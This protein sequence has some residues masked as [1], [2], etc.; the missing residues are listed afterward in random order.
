LNRQD[1]KNTKDFHWLTDG[2]LLIM[3]VNAPQPNKVLIY[4]GVLAVH[5]LF[6]ESFGKAPETWNKKV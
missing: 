6:L 1:A 3:W 5:L 2:I 4:L